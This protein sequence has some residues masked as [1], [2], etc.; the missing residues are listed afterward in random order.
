MIKGKFVV[1]P[2]LTDALD[3]HAA[4]ASAQL[5]VALPGEILTYD[6]AKRT[7]T[8]MVCYNRVYNDGTVKAVS[9]PLVDVPVTTIRGGGLHVAFPIAQGDECWVFFCDINI[10][11]WHKAGGQQTPFDRRRHDIADGFCL[12]GPNSLA[13]PL[14]TAL[15]ASE[16][17]LSSAGAKVAIDEDTDLITIANEADSLKA[18]INDTITQIMNVNIGII[19]DTSTASSI[20]PATIAAAT[21]ANVQLLLILA[22]LE[23][24]LY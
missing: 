7:A 3:F 18:L 15:T 19:A 20:I 6:A 5:R 8:I 4:D 16:G 17:G 21:A 23:A 10:D 22:R 2:T 9:C 24:L 11:A 12:V 13:K 1:P 14:V